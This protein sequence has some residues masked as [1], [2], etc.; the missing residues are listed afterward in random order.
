MIC[1]DLRMRAPFDIY[2]DRSGGRKLLR[3]GNSIDSMGPGPAELRRRRTAA[4]TMKA[5]Q[6]V[7]L[8]G[9]GRKSFATG[10][11]LKFKHIPG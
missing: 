7:K 9:G 8:R 1:P 11:K 2:M 4:R 5:K 10:A 3:S 6:R